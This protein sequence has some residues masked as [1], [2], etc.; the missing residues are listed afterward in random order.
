MPKTQ[1]EPC[2]LIGRNDQERKTKN[3]IEPYKAKNK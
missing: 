1:S 3:V 2:E